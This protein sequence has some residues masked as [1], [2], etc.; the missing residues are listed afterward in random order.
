[1]DSKAENACVA[2]IAAEFKYWINTTYVE[3]A[4]INA[5]HQ[6]TAAVKLAG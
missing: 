2:G 5:A 1:M 6:Q 4:L 3:K